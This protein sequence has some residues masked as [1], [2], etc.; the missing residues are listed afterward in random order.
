MGGGTGCGM[1]TGPGLRTP[2]IPAGVKKVVCR[3]VHI[4]VC[5]CVCVCVCTRARVCGETKKGMIYVCTINGGRG[6]A[7]PLANVPNAPAPAEKRAPGVPREWGTRLDG[8][9]VR[10]GV[11]LPDAATLWGIWCRLPHSTRPD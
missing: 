10:S 5:V 1:H 7:L 4:C 6:H 3:C 11:H 8:L 2:Q 9:H